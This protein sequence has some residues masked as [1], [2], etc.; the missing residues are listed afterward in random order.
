[1]ATQIDTSPDARRETD[2]RPTEPVDYAAL[3]AV[4][5]R[6]ARGVL[7]ATRDRARQDPIDARGSSSRSGRPP[8]RCEGRGA[9]EDR[10]LDARPVRGDRER[11]RKPRG[12]RLRRAVGELLT[13][14]RCVGAWSALAVVGLRRRIRR[15]THRDERAGGVRGE[16]LASVRLQVALRAVEPRREPRL[17]SSRSPT[18][19]ERAARCRRGFA[20]AP[21]PCDA[22]RAPPCGPRAAGRARSESRRPRTAHRLPSAP[23]RAHAA[24]RRGG[25]AGQHPVLSGPP[26]PPPCTTGDASPGTGAA[27]VT[28]LRL[29]QVPE[30]WGSRPRSTR[31]TPRASRRTPRRA[32]R[33]PS[34]RRGSGG[35]GCRRR[36]MRRAAPRGASSGAPGR[37]SP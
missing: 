16:R 6:S 1:M 18:R 24:G 27:H 14:T 31:R 26:R 36:G 11:Q 13:C 8:S 25:C 15:G 32:W 23:R 22:A 3:N 33:C 7:V 19:V 9:R 10:H 29:W 35:G 12:T 28:P 4:Y 30:T 5:A 21:R 34:A 17:L 20:V 37:G 2:D